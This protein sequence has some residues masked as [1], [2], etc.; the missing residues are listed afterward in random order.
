MFKYLIFGLVLFISCKESNYNEDLTVDLKDKAYYTSLIKEQGLIKNNVE[1]SNKGAN[2]LYSKT[3]SFILLDSLKINNEKEVNISFWF[4]FTGDDPKNEQ[5]LISI[6][7]RSEPAKNINFWIA[8]RRLT[9]KINS[10]NL[11]AKEYDYKK[12]GSGLY[13]DLFQLELGKYYFLAI[14]L[15]RES[16]EIFINSELYASYEGLENTTINF[17]RIYLGI[18]QDINKSFKYQ[19][20]GYLRN[21]TIFNKTL[22][23]KEIKVLSQDAYQDIFPYNDAFELGKFKTDSIE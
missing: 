10:N 12:G 15:E 11:W 20:Q 6:S 21:F 22:N 7:D 17:D 23:I 9:G 4:Q 8:G 1:F 18:F 2:F 16:V 5:M 19:F 13:Y 14:N 3:P